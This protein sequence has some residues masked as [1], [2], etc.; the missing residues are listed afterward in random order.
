MK[1]ILRHPHPV[2]EEFFAQFVISFVL[3]AI[4]PVDGDDD[5]RQ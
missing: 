2:I 3:A 4:K 5:K 1:L